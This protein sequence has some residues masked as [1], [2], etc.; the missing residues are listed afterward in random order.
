M[1]AMMTQ[2]EIAEY[3]KSKY[4]TRIDQTRVSRL[5]RGEESVAWPFAFD[6]S[7]EFPE[8]NAKQWKNATPD[9]LRRAFAQLSTDNQGEAA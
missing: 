9:E 8:R 2:T 4:G 6:L 7:I 5:Q 3:F 1:D